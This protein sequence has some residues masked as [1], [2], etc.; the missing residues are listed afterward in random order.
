MGVAL[1][2]GL[3]LALVLSF[4]M[5]DRILRFQYHNHRE[6][7]D[8]QGRTPGMFWSPT[9]SSFFAGSLQRSIRVLAWTFGSE[10]WMRK[11]QYVWRSLW[12]MRICIYLSWA[13]MI[14]LGVLSIGK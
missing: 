6:L 14:T 9:E 2:A 10:E 4:V 5:F 13:G 3:F 12:I 11:E 8:T 1:F 7:W